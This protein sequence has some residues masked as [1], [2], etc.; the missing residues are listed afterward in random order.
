MFNDE[1]PSSSDEELDKDPENEQSRDLN[2]SNES[3]KHINPAYAT[4]MSKRFLSL[5]QA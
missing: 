1:D 2:E 4:Q 3:Q 5:I